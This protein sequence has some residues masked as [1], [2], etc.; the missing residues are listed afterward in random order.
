MFRFQWEESAMND[1]Q[2]PLG[3]GFTAATTA[4][5]ILQGV[6]LTGRN[7]IVTGGNGG[8]GA[9]VARVLRLAGARVVAAARSVPD[10]RL[11]LAD[12]ASVD[13]F[14]A[15]WLATGDPLHIL[16]NNAGIP[17]PGTRTEDARGYEIQFATNHLGHF[18]LT[19]ALLPALR[20]A[21]GARVVTVSSGAQRFGDLRW[22]DLQ[23]TRDYDP[24]VAYSQSKR[25]NV[26]F[27]VE[28]DRRHAA[29]GIRA[30]SCHP[31]VVVGTTLNGAAGDPALH[32]M[33]LTDAA[34]T[35]IID[36]AA[37]K[38]T[39]QQGAATVVLGAA[40]PLLDGLGGVYLKDCDIS[41]LDDNPRQLTP[42]VIPAE[43]VS[44]SIDPAD[45]RR[46]WQISER[47]VSG[48]H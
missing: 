20:A 12:P 2:K 44:A 43:V 28:L 26:L 47:L 15:R 37:G 46:L 3:T 18:Q 14:A 5:E 33:G 45:A 7:A 34:G 36:P 41:P 24:G 27:T 39:V 42:D 48:V 4:A 21:G 30:F 17:S 11:D 16:V 25:A 6:D 8:I 9:E 13:A 40:S 32:A 22:D 31:G 35:P 1:L 19:R 38:K 29:D 23:L 10:W